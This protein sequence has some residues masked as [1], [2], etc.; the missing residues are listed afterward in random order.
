[1]ARMGQTTAVREHLTSLARSIR[2]A[3]PCMACGGTHQVNCTACKGRKK[4]T[5][6][7]G[8]CGGSGKVQAVRGG[9]QDCRGCK[10]K[11]RW[12]NVDCPKC[13]ASGKADCKARYCTRA[14]PSPKFESFAEATL[15]P[16]CRGMGTFM[17]HVAFPCPECEGV[18]MMLQ[19][20]ADP[21]KT[22]R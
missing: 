14:V 12:E 15:C 1:M 9:V 17:R 11:G 13:K 5:M 22:I 8:T 21:S 4:L 19:P 20:K 18:G 7:C 2:D 3:A 6:E 10:G 16:V